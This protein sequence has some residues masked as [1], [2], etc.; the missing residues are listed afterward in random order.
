MRVGKS[1]L[2]C[3]CPAVA[4]NRG[5]E[6]ALRLENQSQ[7][8]VYLGK[9]RFERERPAVAFDGRVQIAL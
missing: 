4:R 1:R 5:V 7:I 8:A 6:I 3:D 9:I 2:H